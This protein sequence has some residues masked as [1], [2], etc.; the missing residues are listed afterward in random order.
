MLTAA[1]ER[2]LIRGV[3]RGDRA[4]AERLVRHFQPSLFAY[5]VRMSGKPD[6]A[7]DVVQEAFCRAL[8]NLHRYD[9]R[10]RFS[11]WLFTIAKR[12]Y[13]NAQQRLCPS[14]DTES[15]GLAS[16][17]QRAGA[18]PVLDGPA[19]DRDGAIDA[20]QAALAELTEEQREVL[21]LYYQ[22]QWP[23]EQISEHLDLPAGTIKSHLHRARQKLRG[24]LGAHPRI[25]G[26]LAEVPA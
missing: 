24:Q 19:E 5:M 6:V 18:R 9:D 22:C 10:F 3:L 23:V 12:V 17:R 15:A 2:D 21:I 26:W 8:T 20:L 7:E 13:V 16:D 4:A 25:I 11:T 1:A 14:F